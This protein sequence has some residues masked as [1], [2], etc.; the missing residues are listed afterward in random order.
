M[1][2]SAIILIAV[3]YF[4]LEYVPGIVKAKGSLASIIKLVG[5]IF[6]ILGVV[7]LI[8]ALLLTLH[9]SF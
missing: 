4:I 1:I 8:Q 9:L 5:I 3:G 7:R 2:V 6:L